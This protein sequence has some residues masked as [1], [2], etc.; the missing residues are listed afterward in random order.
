MSELPGD[1]SWHSKTPGRAEWSWGKFSHIGP[2]AGFIIFAVTWVTSFTGILRGYAKEKKAVSFQG[3][4]HECGFSVNFWRALL[5]KP[6]KGVGTCT[7]VWASP[8]S[9]VFAGE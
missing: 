2:P 4:K 5:N 7:G 8:P 6:Q 1:Q 3:I 9:P